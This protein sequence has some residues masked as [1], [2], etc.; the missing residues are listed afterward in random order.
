MREE[1]RKEM[2]AK[3]DSES[4]GKLNDAESAASARP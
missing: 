3:F 1:R 2:L 4:D